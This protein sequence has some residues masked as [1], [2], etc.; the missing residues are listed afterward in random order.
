MAA[1]PSTDGRREPRSERYD[2]I[3]VGGGLGGLSAGAFLAKGG[4]KV[5]VVERQE[6]PGGYAH[7]FRRGPYTFDPAVHVMPQARKGLLLDTMLRVLGV[8]DDCELLPLDSFYG[9]AFPDLRLDVP[10]GREEFITTHARLFPAEADGLREFIALCARV[11]RESQELAPQLTLRDLDRAAARYPDLFKYRSVTVDEVLD[12]FVRDP[13]LRALLTTSW[14]YLGLPP[15]ELSFFT[16]SGMLMAFLDDG[17]TYCRGSFQRVADAFVHALTKHGGDLVV[18]TP[19]ERIVVEDGRVAGV[20]LPGGRRLCAEIV[21]SNAD[22]TQTFERLVGPE[23]LPA[24]FLR[25]FRRLT[26]C[27]SGCVVYAAT[28]L[29][30]RALGAAHETFIHRDWDHD[31]AYR[32]ILAG[33]PGGMWLNVPTLADPSLA[34]EGEHLAILTSLA[35][36]DIGK[37]WS[38]EK[39]RYTEALL[40]ELECLFPGFRRH[41]THLESATPATLERYAANRAGALYGWANT[42]LQAGSKRPRHDTPIAGLYLAGH[43]AQPGSGSFR[44]LYSGLQ[45]AQL[46]QGYD[47]L[48]A[49]VDTL[50]RD[51][52]LAGPP[53]LQT[54]PMGLIQMISGMWV[55]QLVYVAAKLGIADLLAQRGPLDAEA[56][57]AATGA[58][59][60]TLYRALRALTTVGIFDENER[61]AFRLTPLA[62]L[63][64]SDVEG[65]VRPLAIMFG[66][67]WHWQSWGALH[68]SVMTG[69]PAFEHVWGMGTYQYVT[70]HPEAADV[71]DRAMTTITL[72]A[73]PAVA[74]HYDF[75]GVR[76]LMD[77]CGGHGTLLGVILQA[78]PHLEGVLFDL[79][80]VVAGAHAPLAAA[81]LDGRC[82]VV[83]GDVFAGVPRGADAI[84]A[85]SFIHSFDDDTAV[86]LLRR[87]RDALPPDGR[88]LVVEMV[89]PDDNTPFFGKLFDIEMLTQSDDGRD[90]TAGE[91]RALFAR[92][93][94]RLSRIVHTDTPVSV[95]EGVPA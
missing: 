26:P 83:G 51:A 6:G 32:D 85:K 44:A 42:P 25:N 82:R 88:V 41:I 78:H 22:A 27:L 81:G 91:F 11:T 40:D 36:Y 15:S 9:T 90:R 3:V 87:F 8:E 12:G 74:K 70:A 71:Y 50:V 19:V 94:L 49:Y 84:M 76:T 20:L 93:G 67:P 35:P 92:A 37:P 33:Q 54:R 28:D 68:H 39:G 45:A 10:Y 80:H 16:W 38:D 24:S 60:R 47:T 5:L 7:A 58:H 53:V 75:A 72:Q 69:E 18:G 77:V 1:M 2:V 30:L 56:L 64:R 23:H 46:V 17:P 61:H 63:L 62:N 65:S 55:T 59:P 48:D 34:P 86:G 29:D 21:V 31:A 89:L 13:K 66:E 4:R 43:W 52:G 14:P 79:P 95:I 73:A 57:A